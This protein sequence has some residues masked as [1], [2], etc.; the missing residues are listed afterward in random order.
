MKNEV[1]FNVQLIQTEETQPTGSPGHGSLVSI[2]AQQNTRY[3]QR[4]LNECLVL[5]TTIYFY[6]DK[7]SSITLKLASIKLI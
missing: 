5:K 7:I 1:Q 3:L 6:L 4:K 2:T